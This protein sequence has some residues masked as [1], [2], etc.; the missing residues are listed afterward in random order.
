MACIR[1][2]WCLGCRSW[3][4]LSKCT[5]RLHSYTRYRCIHSC[6][7]L[8]A[9]AEN[10]PD[11]MPFTGLKKKMRKTPSHSPPLKGPIYYLMKI[12][13]NNSSAHFTAI[14]TESN[15]DCRP[16]SRCFDSWLAQ[17]VGSWIHFWQ[18]INSQSHEWSL[19]S[20]NRPVSGRM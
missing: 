19:K 11:R 20:H 14:E 12:R 15:L 10:A 2:Q 7:V 13:G 18:P 1:Y 16:K 17:Y 5:S 8:E 3:W 6:G 4:S 9:T